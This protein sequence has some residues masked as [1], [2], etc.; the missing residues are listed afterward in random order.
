MSLGGE[1]LE[2]G[3]HGLH[4]GGDLAGG[5]GQLKDL[6]PQLDGDELHGGGDLLK[7]RVG[8]GG[9][10]VHLGPDLGQH[11]LHG[12]ENPLAGGRD[13]GHLGLRVIK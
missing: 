13:A 11:A 6:A 4:E 1:G 12:A 8:V 3:V 5:I 9:Q 10:V 2:P 7:E